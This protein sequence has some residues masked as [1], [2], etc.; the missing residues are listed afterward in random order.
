MDNEIRD[1][2]KILGITPEASLENIRKARER[3]LAQNW[4]NPMG[5]V[6]IERAYSILSNPESRREYDEKLKKEL[7]EAELAKRNARTSSE[8]ERANREFDFYVDPQ[9]LEEEQSKESEKNIIVEEPTEVVE[10]KEEVVEEKEEATEKKEETLDEKDKST[11]K[12]EEAEDIYSSSDHEIHNLLEED[13]NKKVYDYIIP[14]QQKDK[15]SSTS[16]EF[17]KLQKG[18]IYGGSLLL[19]GIPGPIIAYIAMKK[20]KGKKLKLHRNKHKKMTDIKTQE[21]K[22]IEEYNQNLDTQINTLLAQPH[23]NYNLQIAKTRYENQIELL[24]KRIELKMNETVKRGGLTKYKLECVALHNQLRIEQKKLKTVNSKINEYNKTEKNKKFRLREMIALELLPFSFFGGLLMVTNG[25]VSSYLVLVGE[26]RGIGNIGLYFTVN[27]IVMLLSRPMAGKISDR[28]EISYVLIPAFT[29]GMLA[30]FLL[31]RAESLP[32]ILLVAVLQAFGAG[33]G[34][35]A[36][37]AECIRRLRRVRAEYVSGF[38]SGP[39]RAGRMRC[40]ACPR[41]WLWRHHPELCPAG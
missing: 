40:L 5:R 1:Y 37:Q 12:K 33:M 35:P 10:K 32:V 28:Y 22:L 30:M 19:V 26:E 29:C 31:S 36:L 3:E 41:R 2:Y 4:S 6:E 38:G 8:F 27:A 21:S 7:N 9:Q 39:A 14:I 25:I 18:L 24:K 20:L 11:H 34:H 13:N 17:T 23:N 16:K 15:E